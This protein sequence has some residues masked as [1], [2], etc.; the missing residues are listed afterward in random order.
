MKKKQICNRLILC[1]LTIILTSFTP[2]NGKQN[3]PYFNRNTNEVQY[4]NTAITAAAADELCSIHNSSFKAG[5]ELTYKAYYNWNFVWIAAGEITFK[6]IDQGDKYYINAK[7]RTYNSYDIF[8][9]VRDEFKVWIDKETML[10]TTSVREVHEGGYQLYDM[11]KYDF[12]KMEIR[13]YRGKDKDNTRQL[14]YDIDNCMH[15]VLSIIYYIRNKDYDKMKAGTD[16][17]V[18]VFLDKEKYSLKAKYV[19]KETKEI[20]DLGTYKTLKLMPEVVSGQVFTDSSGMTIWATDDKNHL[21]LQIESPLSVGSLKA[22]LK[23]HKNLRYSVTAK[24]N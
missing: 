23:S 20:K 10:P 11:M 9:K 15:D 6:V 17:P 24:V 13:S 12:D 8:F 3:N 1:G 22:V 4:Q 14:V 18:R 2:Q 19:G 5:E 21:P 16:I 7:G